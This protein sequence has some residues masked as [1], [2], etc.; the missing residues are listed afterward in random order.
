MS[1]DE[2]FIKTLEQIN[3]V[4]VKNGSY[5]AEGI[6]NPK[7]LELCISVNG[8]GNISLPLS[9]DTIKKMLAATEPAKFGLR[10]Q[11]LYDKNIRD[12]NEISADKINISYNANKF[13]SIL[14]SIRNELGLSQDISLTPHLHNI[15]VYSKGQFFAQHQDTEKLDG[16][17]ATLVMVLPSPHIGGALKIKHYGE[18]VECKSEN[19]NNADIKFIAFYS[20]C[21]HEVKEILDGHR[22]VVTYNLVAESKVSLTEKKIGVDTAHKEALKEAMLNALMEHEVCS[23][24]S[25]PSITYLLNH[26]YTKHG[27]SWNLL[28]G[29]DKLRVELIKMAAQ[30]AKCDVLLALIE[31]RETWTTEGDYYYGADNDGAEPEDLVDSE[32]IVVHAID[33]N[34]KVVVY[35]QS[36][37]EKTLCYHLPNDEFEPFDTEYEGYMGNYGNTVDYWYHRAAVIIY[38][39]S[40]S[41]VMNFLNDSNSSMKSLLDES[42]LDRKIQLE[43]LWPY[44]SDYRHELINLGLLLELAIIVD[45]SSIAEKILQHCSSASI[46]KDVNQLIC[47]LF[48][49]YGQEWALKTLENWLNSVKNKRISSE[50]HEKF[51]C[52]IQEFIDNKAD[53]SIINKLIEYQIK[54]IK[55]ADAA[56]NINK[57][58]SLAKKTNGMVSL[59]KELIEAL[60]IINDINT[61]ESVL[62]YIILKPKLYPA[63][64]LIELLSK[65]KDIGLYSL[66]KTYILN[67]LQTEINTGL[68]DKDD[69]SIG[70]KSECRCDYCKIFNDFMHSQSETNK[71][72]P[73]N[74][75]IRSHIM[76]IIY[77]LEVPINY[78]VE[79]KGRPY[80]LNLAKSK[81][82]HSDARTRF[83]S[84]HSAYQKLS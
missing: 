7:Q 57:P 48:A 36:I 37:S 54:C 18:E 3:D 25:I 69:W 55:S 77:E 15:L 9:G 44:W 72:W 20:D 50:P 38:R 32:I 59:V 61:Q 79:E 52:I 67:S 30:E 63:L 70:A 2:K 12:T 49:H 31:T 23:Y 19:I 78:E 65:I 21:Q 45:D 82:I 64:E 13:S 42:K 74:Q 75:D 11:T 62:K 29:A 81:S 39:K 68:R 71:A 17:L 80:K 33:I 83:E 53:I 47:K 4:D 58:R 84:V 8:C 73:I 56:V 76:G 26:Q 51:D 22:V 28:R 6:I 1:V 46:L 24:A 60:Q 41:F 10:D 35:N 5:Y 27:L 14:D 16:M 66:L 34:S 40:D 43:K